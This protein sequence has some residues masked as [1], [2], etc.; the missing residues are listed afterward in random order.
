MLDFTLPRTGLKILRAVKLVWVRVPPRVFSFARGSCI[1]TTS[2]QDLSID[3]LPISRPATM[4]PN[5]DHLNVSFPGL[6][7][8]AEWVSREEQSVRASSALRLPL[9]SLSSPLDR[10]VK[11]VK[12]GSCG[13]PATILV[14][15]KSFAYLLWDDSEAYY[16]FRLLRNRKRSSSQGIAATSPASN[17]ATR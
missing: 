10:C 6:V 4:L 1:R 16:S 15:T 2:S 11:F 14:P 5:C 7:N 9:W 17:S 8:K 12:K 3:F 13:C